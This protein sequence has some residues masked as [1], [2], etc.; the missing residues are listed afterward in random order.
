MSWKGGVPVSVTVIVKVIVSPVLADVGV[1]VT[2]KLAMVAADAGAGNAIVEV[3]T[4]KT[5]RNART[6][7]SARDNCLANTALL[8]TEFSDI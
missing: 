1:A 2:W 8:L 5:N 7:V 4:N 3:T 6:G